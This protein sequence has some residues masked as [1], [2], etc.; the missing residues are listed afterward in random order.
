MGEEQ[1]PWVHIS[2]EEGTDGHISWVQPGQTFH[3]CQHPFLQCNSSISE[4]E[5]DSDF[6]NSPNEWEAAGNE[7]ILQIDGEM[8]EHVKRHAQHLTKCPLFTYSDK[9]DLVFILSVTSQNGSEFAEVYFVSGGRLHSVMER[10][11]QDL[12][13]NL[14]E[15]LYGCYGFSVLSLGTLGIADQR[16][17]D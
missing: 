11:L 15:I 14:K 3:R 10:F 16:I 17:V 2:W 6:A 12:G 9:R 5:R 1:H 4:L 7:L 13:R 8:N